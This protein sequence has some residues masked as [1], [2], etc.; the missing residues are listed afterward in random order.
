LA[1]NSLV[2]EA[3]IADAGGKARQPEFRHWQ[4]FAGHDKSLLEV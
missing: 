3:V 4:L 2:A 1:A